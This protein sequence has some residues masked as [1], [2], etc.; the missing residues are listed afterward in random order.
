MKKFITFLIIFLSLSAYAQEFA[1]TGAIWY[2][3]LGSINPEAE[4]Y[5]TIESVSDTIIQGIN[6]K[7]L[8]E[9]EHYN[10]TESKLVAVHFVYSSNDSVFFFANDAFHLLYNFNAQTGETI[11]LDY[12]TDCTS[13]GEALK[14]QVQSVGTVLINGQER[15]TQELI[16]QNEMGCAFGGKVIEG[17]G[18]LYFLFPRT[19]LSHTGPLRCYEDASLG[20]YANP[21]YWGDETAQHDCEQII[22]GN[23]DLEITKGVS[24][25]PNPTSKLIT[26]RDLTQEAKYKIIT[27]RGKLVMQGTVLP[28]EKLQIEQLAKGNYFMIV[29]TET[30]TTTQKFVKL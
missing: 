17:I 13:D 21:D 10:H 7:K 18:N 26:V 8:L 22:L 3:S 2:Y 6:C 29:T 20:L 1:P 24:L 11:E 16:A 23:K 30:Q 28:G 9:E 25:Y 19:D 5:K 4:Y 27:Q 15:R 12:Y 14:L